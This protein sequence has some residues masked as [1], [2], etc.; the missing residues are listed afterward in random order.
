MSHKLSGWLKKLKDTWGLVNKAYQ[1][2]LTVLG[3]LLSAITVFRLYLHLLNIGIA[4]FF[5]PLIE[6]Y[7]NYIS[8]PFYWLTSN[9]LVLFGFEVTTLQSD[10]FLLYLTLCSIL[11]RPLISNVIE[12]DN[13]IKLAGVIYMAPSF[14]VWLNQ[15]TFLDPEKNRPIYF[16]AIGRQVGLVLK[17]I[18]YLIYPALVV[19][20]YLLFI[21]IYFFIILLSPFYAVYSLIWA[22][23]IVASTDRPIASYGY[24]FVSKVSKSGEMDSLNGPLYYGN[25]RWLLLYQMLGFTLAL[26]FLISANFLLEEYL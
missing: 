22:P 19:V 1:G 25:Y 17:Y 9:F 20:L 4:E 6:Y 3:I 24:G 23:H 16:F 12:I 10:F 14:F 8:A 26:S 18:I 15:E 11:L 7:S 2:W 5:R 21:I 13:W